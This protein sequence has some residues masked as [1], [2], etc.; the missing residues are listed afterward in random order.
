MPAWDVN[1]YETELAQLD[2][3]VNISHKKINLWDQFDSKIF[4]GKLIGPFVDCYNEECG[5]NEETV[6]AV[7]VPPFA[8]S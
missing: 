4:P 7:F 5:A 6:A 1:D 2:T 8:C 3:E